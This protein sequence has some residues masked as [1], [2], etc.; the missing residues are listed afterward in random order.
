MK[1]GRKYPVRIDGKATSWICTD[2]IR[3]N[4]IWLVEEEVINVT[5]LVKYK[6]VHYK[7]HRG[8][9]VTQDVEMKRHAW[10]FNFTK[11]ARLCALKLLTIVKKKKCYRIPYDIWKQIARHVKDSTEDWK[12][13]K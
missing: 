3:P 9:C 4:G 13:L 10:C 12:W 8:F 7:A 1:K 6:I 11:E 5:F 2:V